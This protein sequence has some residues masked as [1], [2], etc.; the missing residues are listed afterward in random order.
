MSLFFVCLVCFKNMIVVLCSCWVLS[1][2][3]DSVL[4]DN[5]LLIRNVS[6]PN[7]CYVFWPPTWF[8]P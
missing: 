6:G 8:V 3:F 1:V 4:V 7:T 2:S 5:E